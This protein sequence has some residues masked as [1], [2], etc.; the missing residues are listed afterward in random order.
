MH[1][2]GVPDGMG[3][4]G[5][6]DDRGSG[7]PNAMG[8]GM[9]SGVNEARAK[10]DLQ[11]CSPTHRSIRSEAA[12]TLSASQ[13]NAQRIE[14]S[15]TGGALGSATAFFPQWLIERSSAW[16]SIHEGSDLA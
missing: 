11:A 7:H 12:I 3:S 6:R 5:D 13:A 4:G 2:H 1:A 9:Q 15:N 10:P 16:T 8:S 14:A